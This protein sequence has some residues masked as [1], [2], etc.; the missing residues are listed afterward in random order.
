MWTAE[1]LW[2]A[3]KDAVI[4]PPYWNTE[5][6]AVP[7]QKKGSRTQSTKAPKKMATNGLDSEDGI[8][9]ILYATTSIDS[10]DGITPYLYTETAQEATMV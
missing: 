5:G 8:T 3:D 10:T 6:D 7:R 9:T 4:Y 2:T 1:I